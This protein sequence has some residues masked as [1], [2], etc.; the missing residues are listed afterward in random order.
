MAGRLP[1]FLLLFKKE[2]DLLEAKVSG[3]SQQGP[4]ARF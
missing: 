1:W 4:G 2:R 3:N